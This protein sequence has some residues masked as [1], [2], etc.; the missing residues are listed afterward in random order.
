MIQ[1]MSTKSV[2]IKT[3]KK[4]V[5]GSFAAHLVDWSVHDQH[6]EAIF[7]FTRDD[8]FSWEAV[9]VADM[10]AR[11]ADILTFFVV[12]VALSGLWKPS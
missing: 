11:S 8:D 9:V 10:W 3:H 7:N 1:W 6:G 12:V 4:H 5:A 2:M